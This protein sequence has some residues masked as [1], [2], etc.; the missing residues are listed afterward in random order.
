MPILPIVNANE[1][2]SLM[3]VQTRWAA[4]LNPVLKNP[5]L[6]SI[7]LKNIQLA[8]GA[9]IVN[10]LLGRKLQGWKLVRQRAAGSVFDTQDANSMPDLTLQLTSSA[11]MSVDIE[12]F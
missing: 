5:A 9:N 12:V 11:V 1:D 2:E 3:M 7:V 4:I 6:N 8:A 10:H